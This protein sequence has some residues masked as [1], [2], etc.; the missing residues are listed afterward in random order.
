ML[1]ILR[2]IV[3]EVNSAEH[4]SEA[5]QI[6]VKRVR[7]AI[8]T[9]ACTVFLVDKYTKEYVLLATDGLNPQSVGRMRLKP[10]EGLVGL[11]GEREE[12]INI[13]NAPA[14]P[15]FFYSPEF[16]EERFKA[17]LATPIIHHRQLL[18]VLVVQ[19]EEQR[20]FDEVEEAFLVT[21]SAQ[22]GG[23]LAHAESTGGLN[24]LFYQSEHA[25]AAD[26]QDIIFKGIPSS[27]GIGIGTAVV[28]YP[29]ADLEAVPDRKI[30]DRAYESKLLHDALVATREDIRR[31]SERLTTLPEEERA[32]F[33]AYSRILDSA[34][35][36]A[37]INASIQKGQ[38]AQGA[39]RE[40]IDAHILQFSAM[41]DD[42]LRERAADLRDLGRRVLM[43]LQAKQKTLPD[44]PEC[45]ILVGE[46][47][48]ASAL[49]E[50]PAGRLAGIV[51]ATG[52]I[53]SH[54]AI[55]AR[56]LGIPAIMGVENLPVAQFEGQEVIVD[57]YQGNTYV[58]PSQRLRQSFNRLI[59]EQRKLTANLEELRHLSAQTLD[60]HNIALWV[61]TGLATD[62]GLSLTAGAEGVGLY[63]TEVPFMTRECFPTEEEQRV[64]YRQLLN[65]FAPRPVIMRTLDIGGDKALPYFP[66]EEANPFLG[67]RGIRLTLDHPEILLVQVRAM[68]RA[69]YE[70]NN[71]RIM[72]PMISSVSEAEEALELIEQA[73]QEVLQELPISKPQIG[74]MIEVPSAIYQV[75]SLAKRVDFLSVG[76]N[77]LTQYLLAVD[78]NNPRVANLYD[79]MQPAVLHAL[80]AIVTAAHQAGKSVSICGELASEPM[81]V[82]LLLAI[83]F[84]ALSMNSAAIP[85]IKWVIRHFSLEKAQAL[86]AE[87]LMMENPT[88]IRKKLKEALYAAGL[89]HLI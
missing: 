32:L 71:L 70:L 41:E 59:K 30:Q 87:I 81:A 25:I 68:M 33:D 63:R 3:Q 5:L 38:W 17:F 10:G 49:A 56:G 60:G 64:I 13:D 78:R 15:S 75:Y 86:L 57:G 85:R 14:H 27:N 51:S 74:I 29:L 65:A 50:V 9:N 62:A 42:Y 80:L 36:E 89:K 46:E 4:F 40:V 83:G 26:V 48:S 44:Y 1:N 66:V 79:P 88:Q 43:H 52:S 11:A 12:P 21:I 47:V 31:L 73:Y 55:L 22:L 77:D 54:V 8:S 2:R 20:R 53:N 24:K 34:S 16:G 67:W 45:T 7:E 84:D 37:E 39:L 76:S 61:N 72:L 18:G 58:S 23:V 69:S 19:Q 35:L 6:L 82:P 28:I